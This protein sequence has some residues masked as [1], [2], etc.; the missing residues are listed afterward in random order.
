MNISV[1]NLQVLKRGKFDRQVSWRPSH[2][3]NTGM[4]KIKPFLSHSINLYADSW[5]DYEFSNHYSNQKTPD[6]SLC[7]SKEIEKFSLRSREFS[8]KTVV[9]TVTKKKRSQNYLIYL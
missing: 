7:F 1:N 6:N 8:G 3:Q 9:S 4:A 2:D 5:K